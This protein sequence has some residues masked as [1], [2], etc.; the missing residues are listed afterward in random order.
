MKF[1]RELFVNHETAMLIGMH[2]IAILGVIV[3]VTAKAAAQ[4]K[5]Y[6]GWEYRACEEVAMLAFLTPAAMMVLAVMPAVDS[7]LA[8]DGV[9]PERWLFSGG[10]WLAY[11]MSIS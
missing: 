9:H 1:V 3:A 6:G 10:L 4:K 8:A 7:T 11:M 5:A 2:I